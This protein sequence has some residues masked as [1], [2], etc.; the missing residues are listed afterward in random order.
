MHHKSTEL[1]V[2]PPESYCKGI[3]GVSHLLKSSEADLC[4]KLFALLMT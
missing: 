4:L 1:G 3:L 2:L